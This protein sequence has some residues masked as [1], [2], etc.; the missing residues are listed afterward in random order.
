[1]ATYLTALRDAA[2]A[3]RSAIETTSDA[4]AAAARAEAAAALSEISE[5]ASRML[6]SFAPTIPDRTD[7]VWLDHEDNRG[8]LRPVL[9]VAP[10]TV[11]ACYAARCSPVRRRC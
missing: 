5:T 1:M 2:S 11:A 4:K 6:T 10:L 3:A 7:V 8:S 9:R